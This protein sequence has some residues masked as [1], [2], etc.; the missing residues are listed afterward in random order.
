MTDS[1]KLAAMRLSGLSEQDREWVLSRLPVTDQEKIVTL[2]GEF[3]QFGIEGADDS[4]QAILNDNGNNSGTGLPGT[5]INEESPRCKIINSAEIND[6]IAAMRNVPDEIVATIL[7]ER[8]WKWEQD[9]LLSR[10]VNDL[11]RIKKLKKR[12][13]RLGDRAKAVLIECLAAEL[14]PASPQGGNFDDHLHAQKQPK[15]KGIFSK[16]GKA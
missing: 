5:K 9:L 8:N 12:K 1:H 11:E 2:I 6:V 4:L 13:S 15:K 7:A 16:R 10:G 3:E 14:D